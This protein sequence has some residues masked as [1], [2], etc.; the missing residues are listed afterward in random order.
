M[1]SSSSMGT[2]WANGT[3]SKSLWQEGRRYAQQ[4]FWTVQAS[5]ERRVMYGRIRPVPRCSNPRSFRILACSSVV[6]AATVSSVGG[7][8]R[9]E[10][11]AG[12]ES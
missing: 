2:S 3:Q 8:R 9:L 4:S 12:G 5:P 11:T 1:G 10:T 7:R 6:V